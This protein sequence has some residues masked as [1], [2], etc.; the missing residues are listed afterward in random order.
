MNGSLITADKL[1]HLKIVTLAL[2]AATAILVGMIAAQLNSSHRASSAG[3]TIS[4]PV[5]KPG[6]SLVAARTSQAAVSI[7]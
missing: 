3:A 5:A 6:P 4:G 7:R 2:A 1:T